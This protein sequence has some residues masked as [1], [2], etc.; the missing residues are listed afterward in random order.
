MYSLFNSYY[1]QEM[2]IFEKKWIPFNFLFELNKNEL[3]IREKERASLLE[4]RFHHFFFRDLLRMLED[5][6]LVQILQSVIIS[7]QR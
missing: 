7:R 1:F 2:M 4:R 5:S 6:F 3:I